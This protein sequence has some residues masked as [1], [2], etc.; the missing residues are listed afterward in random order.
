MA[1]IGQNFYNNR[2]AWSME[3]LAHRLRLPF[4]ALEPIFEALEQNGLLNPTA[5]DPPTYLPA[6]PLENTEL[7]EVLDAVR[8]D[9]RE[10]HFALQSL[11]PELAVEQL[12]DHFDR[13][14]AGA[15][16]GRTLKDL[17]LLEPPPVVSVSRESEQKIAVPS[18]RRD[19]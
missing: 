7:K 1:L 10:T 9:P 3:G 16:Q 4:E 5:D 8:N 6:R 2:P 15:F 14:I 18:Q 12:V 17:A 19:T 11:E 13:A